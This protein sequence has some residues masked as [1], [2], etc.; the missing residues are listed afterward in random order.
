MDYETYKLL[1]EGFKPDDDELDDDV[2]VD[3]S[4]NRRADHLL[5][6]ATLIENFAKQRI[7][8]SST[9]EVIRFLSERVKEASQTKPKW[10]WSAICPLCVFRPLSREC[11][12]LATMV[13][14]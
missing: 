5:T 12:D 2:L 7:V 3:D 1:S 10:K 6:I 8:V 13:Y 4:A 14:S 11:L 9:R